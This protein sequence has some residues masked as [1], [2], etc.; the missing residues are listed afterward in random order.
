[1]KDEH[2]VELPT[3]E[4]ERGGEKGCPSHASIKKKRGKR[5]TKRRGKKEREKNRRRE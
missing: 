4:R 3:N 2:S 1:M 5:K